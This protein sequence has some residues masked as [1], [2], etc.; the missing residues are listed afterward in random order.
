MINHDQYEYKVVSCCY[1]YINNDKGDMNKELSK[2]GAEG[3]RV[4]QTAAIGFEYNK[5][6]IWTLERKVEV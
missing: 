5:Y 2:L 4:V 3:W 6:V 1:D